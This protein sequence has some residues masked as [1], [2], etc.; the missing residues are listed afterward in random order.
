MMWLSVMFLSARIDPGLCAQDSKDEQ[1]DG[2][3]IHR[4]ADL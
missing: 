1:K 3:N 2:S 4:G